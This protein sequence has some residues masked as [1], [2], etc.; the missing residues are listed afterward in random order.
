MMMTLRTAYYHS[1]PAS[2]RKLPPLDYETLGNR[3][4]ERYA[5]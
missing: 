5:S 2:L 1:G 4:L 3:N